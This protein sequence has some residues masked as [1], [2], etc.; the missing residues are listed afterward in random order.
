[1]L[2]LAGLAHTSCPC[3]GPVIPLGPPR[4]SGDR[5]L[6][7]PHLSPLLL[8]WPQGVGGRGMVVAGAGTLSAGRDGHLEGPGG[9][10]GARG[11]SPMT[12]T[13][14]L[15]IFMTAASPATA[16]ARVCQLLRGGQGVPLSGPAG[17]S[18]WQL[19]PRGP[20][21]PGLLLLPGYLGPVFARALEH[22]GAQTRAASR[23]LPSGSH[24]Q[25]PFNHK[26]AVTSAQLLPPGEASRV[27]RP[28]VR[29]RSSP[30]LQGPGKPRPQCAAGMVSGDSCHP[31]GGDPHFGR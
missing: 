16:P 3:Q 26:G 6:L 20:G 9:H 14:S 24:I 12:R 17:T 1:M 19:L 22:R 29:D 10:S 13:H 31:L 23:G 30:C 21:V 5:T 2:R 27:G 28:G 7:S 18:S 15:P 25:G 8:P 11:T 4:A